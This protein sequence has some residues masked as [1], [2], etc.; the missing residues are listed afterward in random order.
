MPQAEATTQEQTEPDFR[1]ELRLARVRLRLALLTMAIVPVTLSMVLFKAVVDARY[2]SVG[3]GIVA[4]MIALTLIAVTLTVWMTRRIVQPAHLAPLTVESGNREVQVQDSLR[5]SLTGL[6]NHRAF[7]EELDRE[8]EQYSR[9]QVPVALLLIDMD[10]MKLINESGGHATGDE[11]LRE[12]GRMISDVARYADRAF[13]VGGDE[14]AVL[15]PHTDAAGAMQ[16]ARRLLERAIENRGTRRPLPFSGG[17]AACPEH[18]TDRTLIHAQADAA[19][20]WCK[21]HGRSSVDIYHADRDRDASVEAT[22]ETSMLIARIVNERL[23]K[24]AYQ[25][26]VD[27]AT[28]RVLGFEGLS[29]PFPNTGFDNPGAMF[30]AAESAGRTVELDLACLQAVVAGARAIPQDQILTINI[31]PRTIE[32]PHFSTDALIAILGAPQ[33]RAGARCRRADRA[34][35]RRGPGA[36]ADDADGDEAHRVA[37]RR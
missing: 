25:P 18:A 27:L 6:G 24:P 21:R 17:I 26:V 28:G 16:V 3:V 23:I 34:R 37:H 7:Q 5:D 29:R 15:M 2:G 22:N 20:A 12:M 14:F 4:A 9:Y 11:M 32:A 8:L 19:L 36:D 33:H 1:R 30:V 35:A 10:D 31:S 13:R